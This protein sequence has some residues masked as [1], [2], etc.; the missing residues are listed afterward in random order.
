[1]KSTLYKLLF[2][3]IFISFCSSCY[4]VYAEESN[5]SPAN[6]ETVSSDLLPTFQY[7]RY[8]I[9][10]YTKTN[11]YLLLYPSSKNVKV[12]V[13]EAEELGSGIDDKTLK[14]LGLK[15]IKHR[16][17]RNKESRIESLTEEKYSTNVAL[18][19]LERLNNEQHIIK[20]LDYKIFPIVLKGLPSSS[21]TLQAT[22]DDKY[23]ITTKIFTKPAFRIDDVSPSVIDVGIESTLTIE[24]KYLDSFT[25]VYIEGNDIEIK[26]VESTNEGILK[27][28][29]FVAEN[30]EI[31]FR[32]VS[33]TNSL[34]GK[35]ATLI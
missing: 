10:P 13:V 7:H 26:S 6:N 16:R 34:L 19:N 30:A 8:N 21:Y 28:N 5:L 2:F 29:A 22:V 14:N 1:M 32:D 3:I 15:I 31:G 18:F 25:K 4:E 9:E 27:V 24:G 20:G 11:I 23:V 33:V 35:S 17:L 12:E